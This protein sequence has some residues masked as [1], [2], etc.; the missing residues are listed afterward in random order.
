MLTDSQ[1]A[2]M[3]A[4]ERRELIQRLAAP[5]EEIAPTSQWLMRTR[6]IR[7]LVMVASAVL[8]VPWIVYIG[9]TLPHRYVAH[10]WDRTWVGFD[11]LLLVLLASTAVLGYLRRQLV[12][13]T[14]FATGVLLLCDAWFDVLT[15]DDVD[16]TWS[17]VT[18]LIIEIPLAVLLISGSLQMLRLIAARLWA[19]D[20]GSHAWDIRIPLPSDA[21]Q[22]VRRRRTRPAAGPLGWSVTPGPEL[23]SPGR[24]RRSRACG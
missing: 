8:L 5:V 11:L 13:L 24:C 23:S 15:S 4:Q 14:S 1:I 20:P 10:N 2:G 18:A 12:M 19:L 17:A 6:E 22:A 9:I 16:R 7:M 21:D 3:T